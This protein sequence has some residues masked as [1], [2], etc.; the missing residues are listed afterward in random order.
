MTPGR[1]IEV[2][3]RDTAAWVLEH[4]S[5]GATILEIGCGDGHFARE[6]LD[7]GF[8]VAAVDADEQS[9]ARARACGVAAVC[10][11]WPDWDGDPVDAVAFTRSLHH[12]GPLEAAVR[13]ARDV[14]RPRGLLLVDDFAVDAIDAAT[15]E[16]FAGVLRSAPVAARLAPLPRSLA[17][18]LR[19]AGSSG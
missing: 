16:W 5:P 13:K 15:L 1:P 10:T 11:T 8:Q 2:A 7:R 6:M 17:E 14:L 9:V 3:T 12:I 4:V 18:R 19:S